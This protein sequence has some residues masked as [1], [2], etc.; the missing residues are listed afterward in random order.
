MCYAI[1]GKVISIDGKTVTVGYFGE[2]KNAINEMHDLKPGDYVYAQGG[3][4]IQKVPEK[5]ALDILD[6]WAEMFQDLRETDVMLSK[7]SKDD[8]SSDK[9][10]NKILDR[11]T[12]E[13]SPSDEDL[14]Y[15]LALNDEKSK[16][17]LYKTANFLRQKHQ[18]NSCCVHGI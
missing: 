10:L 18:Q 14:K 17:L 8:Q 9:L 3:Y 15:L 1:P 4:A 11:V 13:V 5:E 2:T 7:V 16:Q 6:T 12:N